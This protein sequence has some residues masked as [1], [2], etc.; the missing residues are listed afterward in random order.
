MLGDVEAGVLVLLVDAHADE[1][2]DESID[3]ESGDSGKDRG[4]EGADGLIKEL[5][6][7]ALERLHHAVDLKGGGDG[8][9]DR[10]AGKEAEHQ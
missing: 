9:I 8:G 4:E 1:G 3:K 7:A 5:M 6:R 10:R 2:I